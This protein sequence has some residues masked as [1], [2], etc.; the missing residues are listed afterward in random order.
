MAGSNEG[1]DRADRIEAAVK[2]LTAELQ[3]LEAGDLTPRGDESD[4]DTG[5]LARSVNAALDAVAGVLDRMAA[6]SNGAG[7]ASR[8]A[9]GSL[10]RLAELASRQAESVVKIKDGLQRVTNTV[11]TVSS[12]AAAFRKALDV[13]AGATPGSGS[14]V[15]DA[16]RV[17]Q[18]SRDQLLDS[19]RRV[20]RLGES[21]QE[22]GD[23]TRILEEV[24]D[25][26]GVLAINAAIK[27]A[28]QGTDG[29]I[30][31]LVA[32]DVQRLAERVAVATKESRVLIRSMESDSNDVAASMERTA[33]AMRGGIDEMADTESASAGSGEL[34]HGVAS[35]SDAASTLREQIS[36]AVTALTTL[37]EAG[38][39][40]AGEIARTS[41]SIEHTATLIT[42]MKQ[43]IEQFSGGKRIAPAADAPAQDDA[44]DETVVMDAS[45]LGIKPAS[46]GRKPRS[47]SDVRR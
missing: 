30:L 47:W 46:A 20:K 39:S 8:Q 23:V 5:S 45:E 3:G 24:S 9:Q 31:A 11:D 16:R 28:D 32:D 2:R 7:N 22:I 43:V 17:M 12:S 40:G 25:H 34:A 18:G 19:T 10:G 21:V 4:R 1:V 44:L 38:E 15:G 29:R 27:A 33:S 35:I 6:R 41:Q 14:A 37:Q 26:I 42:Q 36:Q 13:D